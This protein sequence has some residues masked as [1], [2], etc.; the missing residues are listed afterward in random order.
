MTIARRARRPGFPPLPSPA[1]ARVAPQLAANRV[2]HH[3]GEVLGRGLDQ[4]VPQPLAVVQR[5][6]LGDG[7]VAGGLRRRVPEQVRSEEHT[8]ELQSLMRT[9]YAVFCLTQKKFLYYR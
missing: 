2:L 3:G 4:I 9:S 8:S 6:I 1:S 7:T 5:R